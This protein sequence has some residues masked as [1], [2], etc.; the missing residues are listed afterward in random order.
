MHGAVHSPAGGNARHAGCRAPGIVS[1]PHPTA[2][3]RADLQRIVAAVD[4]QREHGVPDPEGASAAVRRAEAGPGVW[5]GL[6]TV[7][8]YFLLQLGAGIAAGALLGLAFDLESRWRGGAPAVRSGLRAAMHVLRSNPDTQVI[9]AVVTIV[10]AA[11]VIIIVVR[12]AWPAQ[13]SRGELP[14]FGMV[15]PQDNSA[16][17]GAVA[18]AVILLVV[19]GPLTQ[20]LAGRHA[21]EQ[22]VDVIANQVSIGMRVPL[23]MLVVCVAPVVEELVFRGVLL[24]GL[25]SRMGA[26]WAIIASAVIFGCAHLP[27]FGFAWY[28]VPALVL[29]GLALGWLRVRTRSLWPPITLHAT[30]NFVAMLAWFVVAMRH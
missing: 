22:N 13:W 8:L 14:G 18:L 20:L 15:P 30:N 19:G 12:H 10:T 4:E 9:V 11:I 21:V 5:T 25:A 1:R 27:D 2:T 3:V 17:A 26:G 6:G 29:L 28:P 24:S 7:A 23:A 16:Y